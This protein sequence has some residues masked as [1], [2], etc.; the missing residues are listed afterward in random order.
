[1]EYSPVL[2]LATAGFEIVAAIWTWGHLV[3]RQRPLG[4]LPLHERRLAVTTGLILILLAGYQLTEVAICADVTTA[5]MLPQVAFGLVT[6]LPA[7]GL[8]LLA[9]ILHPSSRLA[10]GIARAGLV[11]ATGIVAWIALDPAFA[12]ASVCNA[13]YARY[14]HAQPRFLL[15]GIY[16]WSGLLMM[17]V[18]SSV[19]ARGETSSRERRQAAHVLAG[20]SGFIVP[21]IMLSFVVPE[22][23]A[24]L[25]SVL[26]HFAV[27]LAVALTHMVWEF[28]HESVLR[29]VSDLWMDRRRRA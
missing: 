11:T 4:R 6:W 22:T 15:Y 25:P 28:R 3:S 17:L 19:R 20:T 18:W 10:D 9:Q 5:G 16:Y 2:A 21:A 26:C 13:V 24:A 29:I 7:L 23:R 8:L 27:I 12:D 14:I 1:M